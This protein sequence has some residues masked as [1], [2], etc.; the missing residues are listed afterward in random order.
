MSE[1]AKRP[2]AGLTT[3]RQPAPKTVGAGHSI[4]VVAEGI[5]ATHPAPHGQRIVLGRG[6]DCDVRIDHPSVSRHHIELSLGEE[7]TVTDLGSSNGTTVRGTKLEPRVAHGLACGEVIMAGSVMVLVQE[8]IA[9]THARRLWPHSYLSSRLEEECHRAEYEAGACSLVRVAAKT[10]DDLAPVLAHI[11]VLF[12]PRALLAEYSPREVDCLLLNTGAGAAAGLTSDLITHAQAA[13]LAVEVASASLPVDG[14]QA[15]ELLLSVRTQL[16]GKTDHHDAANIVVLDERMRELHKMVQRVAASEISVLLLGETGVGKEIIAEA[17]HRQSPRA[18][19]P[20]LRLNCAALSEQLL[21]SELFGHEK[22]AFTGADKKKVGLLEAANGGTV[23]LDEVGDMPPLVQ[24]KLLRVIEER[25]V[26]PVGS[27]EPRDLDVRFVAAT[28][29]DLDQAIYSGTFRSDLYFRLAGI[30]LT[31]PALRERG[32]EIT[33]LANRFIEERC[34]ASARPTLKVDPAA[35]ELLLSYSWPGNIREL[36]NVI[37]RA[38]ILCDGAVIHREHLPV[39]R[40]AASAPYVVTQGKFTADDEEEPG[41]TGSRMSDAV[42]KRVSEIERDQITAALLRC[43]GNQTE[44][45]KLL[46]ISRRTLLRR[47]D[48]YGIE[49]P[50]KSTNE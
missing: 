15:D 12:G 19:K 17:V 29:V 10:A 47:L 41:P 37:D 39:E 7:M 18:D 1:Q 20:F 50:R 23:F 34:A 28:H 5:S 4:A 27:L 25:R 33:A 40:L 35:A 44:A 30:T 36:R 2:I 11:A 24:V 46:G 49:R 38:V 6:D 32:A 16:D 13:G 26:T 8:R 21:E 3:I 45:A 31:V 42:D 43:G 48:K 22:G 9:G 14:R